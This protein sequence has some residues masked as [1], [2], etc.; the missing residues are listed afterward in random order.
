MTKWR[1][2][3]GYALEFSDAA[4]CGLNRCGFGF[5]SFLAASTFFGVGLACFF[6]VA[7]RV[8]W[9]S[10]G[11]QLV[12]DEVLGFF[13]SFADTEFSITPKYN[14]ADG[15]R[16]GSWNCESERRRIRVRRNGSEGIDTEFGG[17]NGGN[18]QRTPDRGIL[19][20]RC[21]PQKVIVRGQG[22][23]VSLPVSQSSHCSG[24]HICGHEVKGWNLEFQ[25]LSLFAATVTQKT[26]SACSATNYTTN[27]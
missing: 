11:Q 26:D 22:H 4:L 24:P 27:N 14:G 13:R 7:P 9:V 25:K 3:A 5:Y 10:V 23:S 8:Q 19:L 15:D 2:M 6:I 18:S 16:G 20:A 12:N 17:K 21:F 1:Q